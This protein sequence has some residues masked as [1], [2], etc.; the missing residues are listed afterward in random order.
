MPQYNYEEAQEALQYL[1][2]FTD[3]T[4]KTAII[5]GSGLGDIAEIIDSQTIIQAKE[6]PSW[7]SSTAPGHAGRIITGKVSGRPVI[8]LQGRLHYYEGYPLKAVTFPERVLGM[9]G[10]KEIIIT[11]ASGAVNMSLNSGDIIAVRDHINLMCSNP[12]IGQNEPRWNERF[13]D[14]T[15]AYNPELLAILKD[16]GIHQGVYAALAGPSFETPSEVRMLGILGADVVGMSTVPE[17]IVA[18]SMGLKVC[19]LSCVANM[20]AGIEYGKLMSGLEVLE[21]MRAS[22]KRLASIIKYLIERLN[23][24][25]E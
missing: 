19:V 11:N 20:C 22:A 10:V 12:L 24:E 6:I 16:M 8:M 4:P 2:K 13:P 3:T 7:P 1:Q 23:R 21:V 18:N 5:S 25:S 15:H 9:M 17:V 14:M